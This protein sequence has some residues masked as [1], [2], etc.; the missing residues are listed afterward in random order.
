MHGIA[1]MLH[2]PAVVFAVP[3]LLALAAAQVALHEGGMAGA[4]AGGEEML[5]RRGKV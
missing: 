5:R 3:A 2:M 4:A 1:L